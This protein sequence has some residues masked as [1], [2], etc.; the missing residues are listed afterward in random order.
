MDS[1]NHWGILLAV[2]FYEI[3]VIVGIGAFLKTR[4]RKSSSCEIGGFTLAGRS[5]PWPV[6]GVTLALTVLGSPH[7]FGVLEMTWHIGAVSVWF[8]LA[9]V[10]LLVVACTSTGLWA[11]RLNITTMPEMLSLIFGGT[12][13]LM[14]SCVMAGMVWGILTLEAQGLGIIISTISG[15]PIA[16]GAIIGGML[17][18]LYV[19]LA[20]MKEIGWVNLVNCFIMYV[21]LILAF[22]YIAQGIPFGGWDGVAAVYLERG[23]GFML[24]MT[25]TPQL[26]LTFGVGTVLATVTCHSVAQQLIQPALAA[27]DE[28]TIKKA[29]WL[30]APLNGFFC[31][32]VVCIGLAA[33]IDP[34]VN[35]LGPKLAG[36]AMFMHYLPP[37]L[38]ALLF[39]TFL[40]AVLSSFAASVLAPATIFTIDIYK[41]FFR[42]NLC[43]KEEALV[44]R[45]GIVVLAALA[46]FAA[47]NM[48]PIVSAINWLFAWITPV[49]F[50]IL[51]GLFWRRSSIAATTTLLVAWSVNMLWSF[52]SLAEVLGV[53]D[54]PNVYPALISSLVVS[55]V[56]LLT[57]RTEPGLFRKQIFITA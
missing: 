51:F 18:T 7:I 23:Q 6:V 14:V 33:K 49:F 41:N 55:I 21:G 13:R 32:F 54:V 53:A 35:S 40:A 50:L 15:L 5:L 38:I 42:P 29:L 17:G 37:W 57:T 43:E 39:A 56:M 10:V 11:R 26:L 47:G 31:V 52:T 9:H 8:G 44:T 2:M 30:A 19:V 12:P 34:A 25:G 24:S 20:G 27:K 1:V 48:P 28:K 16:K 45:I 3:V 36:P 4:E 22:I 46:I